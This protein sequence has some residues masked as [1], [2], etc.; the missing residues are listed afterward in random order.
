MGTA[1]SPDI[2]PSDFLREVRWGVSRKQVEQ[3][4]PGVSRMAEDPKWNEMGFFVSS[5]G[6]PSIL[7]FYFTRGFFG[8][9]R[10]IRVQIGYVYWAMT[11]EM[12][13]PP[14]RG[15][16]ATYQRFDS[17]IEMAYRRVR[18]DLVA[19]YGAP[20]K[21]L[22]DKQAPVEFRNSGFFIWTINENILTLQYGLHR[23]GALQDN[24]GIAIGY[25]D[26]NSDPISQAAARNL[27]R[28]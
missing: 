9:D 5:Y 16:E 13:R 26:R 25:G 27:M 11:L 2:R 14:D 8:G 6:V 20:H 18:E 4:F 21:S 10:L 15:I 23:D 19:H 17:E 3:M 22:V 28:R 24:L 1:P 12:E 7:Y